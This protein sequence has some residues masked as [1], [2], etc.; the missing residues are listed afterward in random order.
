MAIMTEERAEK[1]TSAMTALSL[2]L[3]SLGV[4]FG[5]ILFDPEIQT[6]T[7]N[8]LYYVGSISVEGGQFLMS[9]YLRMVQSPEHEVLQCTPVR[10]VDTFTN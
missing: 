3:D 7:E 1:I 4:R 2:E 5:A 8:K 6:D 10:P 9:E